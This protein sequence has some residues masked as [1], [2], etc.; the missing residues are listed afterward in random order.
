MRVENRRGTCGF[1]LA[2]MLI[3][4][5]II[6]ILTAIS[7]PIFTS[8]MHKAKVAADMANLRA[9]FSQIQAE[10]MLTGEYDPSIGEDWWDNLRYSVKFSDGTEAKLQAGVCSVIRPR[11]EDQDV[12]FGYQIHYDCY[13]GDCSFTLEATDST[14]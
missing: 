13:K 11:E 12:K 4:V 9:Y 7:I 3:V 10:Y 8:R 5:A 2:E 14:Y 6:G 1:T